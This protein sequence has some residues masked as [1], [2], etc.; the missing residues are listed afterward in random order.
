MYR[1]T[2]WG[3]EVCMQGGPLSYLVYKREFGGDLALDLL[4]AYKGGKAAVETFLR[5]AWC[6]ARTYD[7][8]VSPPQRRGWEII[9]AM[10]RETTVL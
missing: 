3:R 6:M 5:F 9:P 1:G 7:A 4:E 10:T 8:S 2:I